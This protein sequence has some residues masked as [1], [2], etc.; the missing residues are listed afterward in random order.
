MHLSTVPWITPSSS[1]SLSSKLR[2]WPWPVGD[3][4]N[5]DLRSGLRPNGTPTWPRSTQTAKQ[6]PVRRIRFPVPGLP[7]WPA[8]PARVGWSCGLGWTGQSADLAYSFTLRNNIM[9]PRARASHFAFA[10]SHREWMSHLFSG[11]GL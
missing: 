4:T 8:R 6:L 11:F 7:V 5:G 1:L 3:L 2:R 9:Q 10:I